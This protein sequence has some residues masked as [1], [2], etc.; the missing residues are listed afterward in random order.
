MLRSLPSAI[1]DA[2]DTLYEPKTVFSQFL[3][4]SS[5]TFSFSFS[6]L[7]LSLRPF[8]VLSLLAFLAFFVISFPFFVFFFFAFLSFLFFPS[9]IVFLFFVFFQQLNCVCRAYA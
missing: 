6:S 5:M 3:G 1:D 9:F 2:L 7:F 4:S 8:L